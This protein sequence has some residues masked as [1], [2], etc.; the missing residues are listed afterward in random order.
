MHNCNFLSHIAR[1]TVSQLIQW[2]FCAYIL[3]HFFQRFS[4]C[5]DEITA[6][7]Y[8]RILNCCDQCKVFGHLAT[9]NRG[10]GSFFQFICKL[11]QFLIA[12][13]FS[14]FTKSSCPCKNR[15]HRVGRS[16]FSFQMT[17]I[18][19]LYCSMSCFIFVISL[20]RNK[21]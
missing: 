15:C 9:F 2:L 14:T 8:S 4:D 10:K 19:S 16:F 1:A 17:I 5:K 12:I 21:Y 7:Q 11:F 20:R 6:V 13:Q 18:M 3:N